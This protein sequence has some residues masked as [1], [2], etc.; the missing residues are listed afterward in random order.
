MTPQPTPLPHDDLRAALGDHAEGGETLRKLQAELA[1]GQPDAGAVAEHVSALRSIPSVR[2][3][4]ENWLESP[5]TQHWLQ[6]LGN[7]GL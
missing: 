5:G 7:V 2:P 6:V 4:V 3:L 1:S